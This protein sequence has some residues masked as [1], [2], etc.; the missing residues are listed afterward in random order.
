ME[1]SEQVVPATV[2]PVMCAGQSFSRDHAGRECQLPKATDTAR[3]NGTLGS[4]ESLLVEQTETD[5]KDGPGPV[6]S[7]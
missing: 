4:Q 6:I 7:S 2:L 5:Q 3:V 1:A